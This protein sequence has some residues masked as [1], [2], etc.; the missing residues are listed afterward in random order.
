M[1]LKRSEREYEKYRKHQ[2]EIEKEQS[3][4]EIENDIK[5]LRK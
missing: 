4:K 5:K 3:L 2:A 1:M